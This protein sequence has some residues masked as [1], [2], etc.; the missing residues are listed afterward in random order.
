V[1]ILRA[2]PLQHFLY[3]FVRCKCGKKFGHRADRAQ[4]VCYQCGRVADLRQVRATRTLPKRRKRPDGA[5]PAASKGPRRSKTTRRAVSA[6]V[7][8]RSGTGR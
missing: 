7:Q 1:K 2:R 4:I 8:R 3:L 5:A 6:P